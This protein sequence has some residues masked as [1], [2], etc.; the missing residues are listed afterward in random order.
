MPARFQQ[1]KNEDDLSESAQPDVLAAFMITVTQGIAVQ[2]K[3]EAKRELLEAVAEQAMA[4]WPADPA[5]S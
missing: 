4:C 2:A 5:L 1:A 3:A